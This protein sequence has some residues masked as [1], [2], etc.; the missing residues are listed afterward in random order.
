MELLKSQQERKEEFHNKWDDLKYLNQD[1]NLWLS[2]AVLIQRCQESL[3]IQKIFSD[4]FTNCFLSSI[5]DKTQTVA[6]PEES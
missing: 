3:F 1:Q 6:I 2:S 5:L 4:L